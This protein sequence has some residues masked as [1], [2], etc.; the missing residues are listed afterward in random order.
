M[1]RTDREITD[2]SQI[3]EIMKRCGVCHIS[4]SNEY[5]YVVPMNFG[6]KIDGEEITLYFHGADAV[7]YTH[8]DVYKRQ[9]LL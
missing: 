3:V 5:P 7:S 9:V 4:F 1:R 8:L 2:F 6:M